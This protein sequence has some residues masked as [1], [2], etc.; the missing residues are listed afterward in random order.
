MENVVPYIPKELKGQAVSKW[1]NQCCNEIFIAKGKRISL[2]WGLP[3]PFVD[4]KPLKYC[5]PKTDQKGKTILF[6]LNEDTNEMYAYR[7][8]KAYPNDRS[9]DIYEITK[10]K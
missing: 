6:Y 10:V 4:G 2:G 7:L 8:I 9:K 1:S 3:F 5:G